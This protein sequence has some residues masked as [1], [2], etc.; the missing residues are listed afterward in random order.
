MSGRREKMRRRRGKMSGRKLMKGGKERRRKEGK[1]RRR[2]EGKE[3]RQGRNKKKRDVE[4]NWARRERMNIE[5]G[6]KKQDMIY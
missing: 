4:G 5:G 3:M 2:K 6:K 1:E